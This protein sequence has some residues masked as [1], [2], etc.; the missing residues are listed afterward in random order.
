MYSASELQPVTLTTGGRNEQEVFKLQV[1]GYE[2]VQWF[3]GLKY[4]KIK[5]LNFMRISFN[6]Y[7]LTAVYNSSF[8]SK[9]KF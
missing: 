3:L 2:T 7:K 5:D 1:Y 6:F 4:L 8:L 9:Y